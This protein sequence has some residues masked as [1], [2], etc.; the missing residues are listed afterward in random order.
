MVAAL[1]CFFKAVAETREACLM[2]TRG[3][4]AM[5]GRVNVLSA[6]REQK[7]NMRRGPGKHPWTSKERKCRQ[8]TPS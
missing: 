3:A 1:A 2:A 6:W 7:A 5:P 4:E 8:V